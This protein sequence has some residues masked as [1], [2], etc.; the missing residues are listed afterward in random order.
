[1]KSTLEYTHTHT[2]RD[3]HIPY[4]GHAV[5]NLLESCVVDELRVHLSAELLVGE[6]HV[7]LA[8]QH[9]PQALQV[10]E[11]LPPELLGGPA[12]TNLRL[13]LPREKGGKVTHPRGWRVGAQGG[14][15]MEAASCV[16]GK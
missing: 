12:V 9:E 5:S 1:M 7:L 3:R 6:Q 15:R 13:L 16:G 2:H 11:R 10:L 4:P 14:R 8:Q